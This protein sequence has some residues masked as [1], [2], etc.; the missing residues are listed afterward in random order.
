MNIDSG[1]PLLIRKC[2]RRV[3]L[4][5][6][7]Y[8]LFFENRDIPKIWAC[9]W[10]YRRLRKQAHCKPKGEKIRVLFI[11]SEMA[12]WKEQ[13][14]Y[15]LMDRTED[16]YPIVG[17]SA[18]NYLGENRLSAGEY[19]RVQT[20]TE[21]F[22][23]KMG[24]RHVRTVTIEDGKWVYHDLSEFNPDIVFYTEQWS[25]C[26]KQH[27]YEVSKYAL[28]CFL[29]YYVPDFGFAQIDCHTDVSR[30]V[31]TYFCLNQS[32][33][34]RYRRSMWHVSYA[35]KYVAT[36][37]PALDWFHYNRSRLPEKEYVIY[38]PHCSF[39]KE[40]PRRHFCIGTFDWSG[41]PM[42]EYAEAHPEIRW[43]YKPHP[44]L[45]RRV[46]D[47]GLMTE[48]EFERYNKR[49]ANFAMVSTDSDYQD[50]FLESRVLITDCGSFLP[51]YGSTLRPVIRLRCSHDK[52]VPP[53][54]AR[55]I[56][57][58]YYNVHNLTELY[59]KLKLVVEERQDPNRRIRVAAVHKAKL[60]D[61][62]ASKNI[63]KYLMNAF[64]R[65]K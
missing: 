22:F 43:V 36:G 3:G 28:T 62:D 60:A 61:E 47:A 26:P 4:S 7:V 57:D 40:T 34:W 29:P 51:E 30:M 35:A 56:Y 16:F 15:E 53:K 18:W 42:L 24:D 50:L 45:K 63:V 8:Q 48:E 23:D 32:W 2:L 65:A 41:M 52:I 1:F 19:E 10:R 49:W 37:H 21:A 58:A 54:S 5:L 59:E 6:F 39:A 11:V 38:A 46:L 13:A 20:R 27:P 33:V 31:W 64:G 55:R 9:A 14:L 25:P 12:K 17:I 44:V